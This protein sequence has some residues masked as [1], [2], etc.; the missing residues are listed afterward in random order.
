[1]TRRTTRAE[2]ARRAP[3]AALVLA[4]AASAGCT[5]SGGTAA[6]PPAPAPTAVAKLGKERAAAIANGYTG[7]NLDARRKYWPGAAEGFQRAFSF[8][9][10]DDGAAYLTAVAYAR[11]ENAPATLEWLNQLWRLN[12]CLFPLPKTFEGVTSDPRFRDLLVVLRAQLPKTH[13][14][15]VAF[16][17]AAGDLLP[18]DLAWDAAGKVFYVASLRKRKIVRVKP[19]APGAPALADDFAG[20]GAEPLDAV[21]G[22][23]VDAARR[24]LWAVTAADPAMEGARPDDAGRSQLVAFDLATGAVLGRFTPA[25]R[26]PHQ[27]G[28]LAVGGDGSVWV[29]D[30]VSGEVQVLR[31]GSGRTLGRRA[32]GDVHRAEGDR[33]LARRRARLGR[34]PRAR[35]LPPRPG[36]RSPVPPRPASRAVAGGRR[37]A[38]APSQ[39]PRRRRGHRE[40]RARRPL[41]AR[42]RR[43][44]LLGRSMSSTAPTR[45]TGCPSA[46][47]SRATTTSTWR[48]ASSTRSAPTAPCR[49]GRSSTTSCSCACRSGADAARQ[50]GVRRTRKRDRCIVRR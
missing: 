31:R 11:Q 14:S 12:S 18:G 50:R 29:T 38:R 24:R 32:G 21:L 6:P 23:K 41:D 47:R 40:L 8:N 19:G 45:P 39:R 42:A 10:T 3:A 34:G 4:A 5:L 20:S 44:F 28:G 27:F 46:G 43:E 17:L 1:M 25:T 13:R 7:G 35:R 48:T 15:T 16:T 36:D 26:P 37:R 9:P 22:V 2:G 49:P 30:T 33:G